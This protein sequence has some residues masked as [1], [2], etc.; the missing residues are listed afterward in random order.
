MEIT[1]IGNSSRSNSYRPSVGSVAQLPLP[2]DLALRLEP[3]A[4][5][6]EERALVRA[7]W[8]T[9]EEHIAEVGFI[10]LERSSD[11]APMIANISGT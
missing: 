11:D 10:N 1:T 5:L 4:F 6:P 7:S 3:P 8:Q 9:V 2:W